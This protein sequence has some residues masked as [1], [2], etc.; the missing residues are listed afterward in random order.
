MTPDFN[1]VF[2]NG[3]GK[4]LFSF[5]QKYVLLYLL[6][7]DPDSVPTLEKYTADRNSSVIPTTTPCP[8]SLTEASAGNAT[9]RPTSILEGEKGLCEA[10]ATSAVDPPG[11]LQSSEAGSPDFKA[12]PIIPIPPDH[13][14]ALCSLRVVLQELIIGG[15]LHVQDGYAVVGDFVKTMTRVY[16]TEMCENKVTMILNRHGK[17][18]L[19]IGFSNNRL[20]I[21][22]NRLRQSPLHADSSR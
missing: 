4:Q 19:D 17:Q 12:A 18:F 8:V 16:K 13:Y 20:T 14:H 10:Q 11:P 21:M 7:K 2:I 1:L 22:T 6:D 15:K 5:R 3:Y 9:Q